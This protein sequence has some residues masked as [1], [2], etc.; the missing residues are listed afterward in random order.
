MPV[1][2][3][4]ITSEGRSIEGSIASSDIHDLVSMYLTDDEEACREDKPEGA[5]SLDEIELEDEHAKRWLHVPYSQR[6]NA[7][8][9]HPY[10]TREEALIKEVQ[11]LKALVGKLLGDNA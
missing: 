2:Q 3:I 9:H 5:W 7:H 6:P 8:A 11:E 4:I 1:H 10:M